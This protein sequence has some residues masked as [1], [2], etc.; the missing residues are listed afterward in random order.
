M[1]SSADTEK[2]AER[3][4]GDSQEGS[5]DNPDASTRADGEDLDTTCLVR[6]QPAYLRTSP[7]PKD[8]DLRIVHA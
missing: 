7:V 5:Q 8:A 4:R 6:P 2:R 3:E 1:S